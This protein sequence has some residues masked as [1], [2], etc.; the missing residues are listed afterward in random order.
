MIRPGEPARLLEG[1]GGKMNPKLLI[2]LGLSV[3]SVLS[4][5][6]RARDY[7]APGSYPVGVRTVVLVDK[8]RKDEYSGGPRTLVTEIWY[9]AAEEAREG[10]KATFRGFF[11]QHQEAAGEFVRHFGG[12][13]EEV[14]KRFRCCGVRDAALRK[15]RFP[16]LV[17]SHGNGGVRHQN[18]SQVEHLAGHGYIVVSPDHTGNAGLTPLPSRALPY[19]RTGRRRSARA[20]PLDVSFL[21]T[22]LLRRGGQADSWLS[23]R[24]DPGRIGVLGHSFGGFTACRAAETDRRVK[25]ILP[26]TGAYGK[27]TSVPMLLMLGDKDRTMGVA[28][29]TVSRLFYESCGGPKYLVSLKRGG[30]FSFTDIDYIAPGF[31]DGVGGG[32]FLPS[33]RAKS[34]VNAYSLAFFEHYLR[35][36]ADSGRFLRKNADEKELSLKSGNLPA[37]PPPSAGPSSREK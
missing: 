4:A 25:A 12:R 22:E 18:I 37:R 6:V 29:N 10:K 23:G 16:L 2:L 26:M 17:F 8:S 21:I 9:P 24:L 32:E 35:A 19:D 28:G 30:H 7:S 14:E 33:S 27:K 20:R 36:D 31:G 1:R 3:C 13:I 34:L 11:G 15:G 5:D